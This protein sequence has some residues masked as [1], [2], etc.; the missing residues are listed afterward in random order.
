MMDITLLHRRPARRRAAAFVLPVVLVLLTLMTVVVL[1]MVRRAT[2]DARLAGNIAELVTNDMSAEYVLRYCE[3]WAATSLPGQNARADYWD[4]PRSITAPA[5][6]APAAWTVAA[7]WANDSVS[8]HDDV[9]GPNIERGE[10]LIED[11]TAEMESTAAGRGLDTGN[12][13]FTNGDVTPGAN[14][15]N[16][17]KFRITA[18]AV[19]PVAAGGRMSRAQSEVRLYVGE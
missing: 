15:A 4:T 1:F 6:T 14:P 16:W 18:R 7:N 3:L 9:R 13:P 12:E 2:V 19:G 17:R 5:R 10:C 11:A 8:L